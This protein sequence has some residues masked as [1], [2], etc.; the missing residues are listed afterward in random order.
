MQIIAGIKYI[1]HPEP[2]EINGT[3][4]SEV[5][6]TDGEIVVFQKNNTPIGI[7]SAMTRVPTEIYEVPSVFMNQFSLN[8]ILKMTS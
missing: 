1:F 8:D 4:V 5:K 2:I 3:S 6:L 7:I